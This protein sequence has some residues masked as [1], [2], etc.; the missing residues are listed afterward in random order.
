[1]PEGIKLGLRI[2]LELDARLTRMENDT[3]LSRGDLVRWTMASCLDQWEDTLKI[4]NM[5][6]L[7]PVSG[8]NK[9]NKCKRLR[10]KNKK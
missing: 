10:R 1:M 3:G 8:S 6:N 4:S 2:S 9:K 7:V 5:E